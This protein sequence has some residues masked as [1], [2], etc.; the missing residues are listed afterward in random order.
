MAEIL[1]FKRGGKRMLSAVQSKSTKVDIKDI[2]EMF[3]CFDTMT[4]KKLQKLCYYAYSWHLA[5]YERKLFDNRFEAWVHGPVCPELYQDY[6]RYGWNEIPAKSAEFI[7]DIDNVEVFNFVAEVYGSYGHL[8]AN[9]LEYLTHIEDPWKE[10]RGNLSELE[11][12]N[13]EI[14]DQTIIKYYRR[15][16]EDAQGE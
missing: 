5:L 9:E 7:N 4:H 15:V 1:E 6:K 8:N 10:A 14:S 16:M 3:L 2:A 11:P 12:C 13:E